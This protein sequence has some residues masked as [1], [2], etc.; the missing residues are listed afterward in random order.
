MIAF[1]RAGHE[2]EDRG[3]SHG[4]GYDSCSE[5]AAYAAQTGP[6][7][8]DI[9]QPTR[10]VAIEQVLIDVIAGAFLVQVLLSIADWA[11]RMYGQTRDYDRRDS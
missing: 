10:P 2:D 3:K 5:N 9:Y 6:E 7:G 4:Y 1:L 11:S 8:D